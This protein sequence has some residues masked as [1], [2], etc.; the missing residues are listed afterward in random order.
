VDSFFSRNEETTER[1]QLLY[2]K[3]H[4][5]LLVATAGFQSVDPKFKRHYTLFPF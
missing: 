4:V 1:K 2:W 5:G 3:Q